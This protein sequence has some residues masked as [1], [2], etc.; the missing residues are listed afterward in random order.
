M[1][2][3][4]Q[5]LKIS[6]LKLLMG[7]NQESMGNYWIYSLGCFGSN[8]GSH[9]ASH[10]AQRFLCMQIFIGIK[11]I[12]TYLYKIYH[13]TSTTCRWIYREYLP[14]HFQNKKTPGY[15]TDFPKPDWTVARHMISPAPKRWKARR[16]IGSAIVSKGGG[17]P[18]FPNNNP[19]VHDG[20]FTYMNHEI[21]DFYGKS[22]GKYTVPLTHGVYGS[23]FQMVDLYSKY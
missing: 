21:L 22:V 14:K 8:T 10:V 5:I 17:I 6:T 15:F 11:C 2:F 13:Q 18:G 20:I 12:V 4:I 19:W 16:G 3:E 7:M 23:W 1:D 9:S